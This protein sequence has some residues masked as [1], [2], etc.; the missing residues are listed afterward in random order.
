MA[1]KMRKNGYLANGILE[2]LISGKRDHISN[3]IESKSEDVD[4]NRKE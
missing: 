3:Y 4:V 1:P 2:Q